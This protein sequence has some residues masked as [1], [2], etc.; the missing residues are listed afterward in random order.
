MSIEALISENT[1]QLKR[2][3][4]LLEIS[5]ADRGKL[6][7]AAGSGTPTPAA[8]T[9]ASLT[10]AEIKEKIKGASEETLK[11]MLADENAGQK[12][13]TAVA[14]IEAAIDSGNAP[15]GSSAESAEQT[16]TNSTADSA[17]T[18][19]P[20][21]DKNAQPVPAAVTGEQAAGA[22]G[23][24]FKETDD[25]DERA[26]RRTFVEQIVESL[27]SKIS[28]LDDLGRRKSIFFL[29]RKR[30]GMDVD[31]KAAYDFDGSPT[32]ELKAA[33]AA[34]GGDDLL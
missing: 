32:Q 19:S 5:N 33:A 7:A 27:G 20:S 26:V 21:D 16:A 28:E 24:W 13:S 8:S 1:A 4:D 10:V 22:F 15:A 3:A 17:T 29:R 12:R 11:Q 25:E 18:A 9:A 34:T 23:A 6:L 14:A 2:V 31:F 30:A